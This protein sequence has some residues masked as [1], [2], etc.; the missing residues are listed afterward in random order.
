MEWRDLVVDSYLRIMRVLERALNGLTQ[1]DLN[2][3]PHP[4]CNSMGWLTWHLTRWQDRQVALLLGSEQL[5]ISKEWYA[6]FNRLPDAEDT[7]F[8]HSSQDVAAFKSP[9]AETLL[10]YHRAVLERT[11]D[12]IASLSADELSRDVDDLTYQRR[13]VGWLLGSN[14]SDNLRHAGQVE[15]LRGLLQGKG[16]WDV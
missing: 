16:W 14:I 1:D 8:G 11:R 6:K 2:Q 4:D 5:W 9:D 10:E 15:Y 13:T 3:Q 7:G 12:Y